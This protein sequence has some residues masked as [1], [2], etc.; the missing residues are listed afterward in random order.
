MLH[1]DRAVLAA[2]ASRDMD[3]CRAFIAKGQSEA[4]FDPPPRA[5]GSY[6]ELLASKDIEAVYIPLPTGLRKEWVIRAAEAGKHVLC[7][8]PCALS[9]A[10][11][12]QMIA[13]CAKNR[14]QFMD[15]VMFMHNPRMNRMREMLDDGKSV[16]QVRRIASMFSFA[17]SGK[18]FEEN[19]RM[20]SALEPAGSLGD[21]GWYCIRFI[22]WTL[23]GRMP[24]QVIG[25]TLSGRGGRNSPGPV[26]VDFSAE[27]LFDDGV[28]AD[29]YS[30]FAV[31]NQQWVN[32]SGD[33][34]WL[35]VA[36]FVH[37][38]G[39]SHE[40]AFEVNES[41]VRV[42]VCD[43]SG[44]HSESLAW[45]Q[46]T[47]MI[48]HFADQVQSGKLNGDWPEMALKTQRVMD[49]C[50]KSAAEGRPVAI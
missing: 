40:P 47:F 11:L 34:G 24:R 3:R 37:I 29:L 35:R 41:Q 17:G 21:L 38:T 6:E 43:C 46:E 4:P 42:K 32:V 49:A 30:S 23:K 10:D 7:E 5:V 45:M 26:P 1:S 2:V 14:V 39:N 25:H 28:S 9:A 13:A 16:G 33:K 12:E 31:P 48:R 20:Q 36:D 8:K 18:F 22:L 15:G 50:L 27:L 19:I 44:A